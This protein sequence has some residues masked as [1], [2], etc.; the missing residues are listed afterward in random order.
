MVGRR[1]YDDGCAVAHALDLVGE[2]WALL[3]VRELLLGP[4]RF[5][6]LQ[7]G[8]PGAS[9]DVLTQRLREL[10]EVGVLRRRRLAPPAASWVYELTEW[11]AELQPIV[12][13]LGRWSSRSPGLRHDAPLGVDSLV[14]SLL[15]LF[16]GPAAA[17]FEA[18]VAL[19]LG[20]D[21]F[22]ATVAGGQLT[23][24]RVEAPGPA[25]VV[26]D[27]D[28]ATL[29]TLLRSDRPLAD[30]I[31]AGALRLTGD[32]AVADR[33]RRLFPPPEPVTVGDPG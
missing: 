3:V 25:D 18:T 13:R 15:A 8:L 33:F 30:A 26:L 29:L 11:G 20:E 32:A 6:D 5:T 7:S 2:R 24:S 19:H 28:Q 9:P 22:R 4:K 10:T 14:L 12:V 21:R 16:D 1:K 23:V 27:T 17:G 31:D